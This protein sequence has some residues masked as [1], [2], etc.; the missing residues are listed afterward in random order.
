MSLTGSISGGD[1]I[2]ALSNGTSH[3][4]TIS[5][6]EVVTVESSSGDLTGTHI[7]SSAPVLVFAGHTGARTGES[8][9][10]GCCNDHLEQQMPPVDTWGKE[11]VI[12]RSVPR[13]N[14]EDH[15]RVL[16][17]EHGTVVTVTVDGVPTVYNPLSAG[18]FVTFTANSHTVVS[19]SKPVLVA[20]FLA[21]RGEVGDQF[22]L[23][24]AQWECGPAYTCEG[25][26]CQPKSCSNNEECGPGHTCDQSPVFP[27]GFECKPIGDPAMILAVPEA[28]WQKDFVF[29]TP[30]SYV[31]DYIN[32]VSPPGN[33]IT[34]D[35]EDI[36]MSAFVAVAGSD[37]LVYQTEVSDGVHTVEAAEAI[38]I[39]VYGY[40]ASVSYGYP[41]AMGLK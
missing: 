15:F 24:L 10:E 6:G 8:S 41:A 13:G 16:A 39:V 3:T 32:M 2:P 37:R 14:E 5:E 7:T 31:H 30:S 26:Q 11:F 9:P 38:S 20:Q 19:A 40:D 34:M 27:C 33:T 22:K 1:D 12:A 4:F 36:P 29:L 28:Q 25:T 35:G 18:G 23:C 17:S 21:S